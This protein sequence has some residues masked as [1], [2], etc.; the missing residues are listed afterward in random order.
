MEAMD[1][2][3]RPKMPILMSVVASCGAVAAG[4]ANIASGLDQYEIWDIVAG[5]G[6]CLLPSYF[7]YASSASSSWHKKRIRLVATAAVI[8]AAL[9]ILGD[10]AR[11]SG[12]NPV[13]WL[14]GGSRVAP[15]TL[16]QH[17][18]IYNHQQVETDGY[19][20]TND[21]GWCVLEAGA[22]SEPR[23]SVIALASKGLR[24]K[25]ASAQREWA[26]VSGIF[27][28]YK[29]SKGFDIPYVLTDAQGISAT[30]R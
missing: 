19:L 15:S 29:T 6:F 10:V 30:L 14:V 27:R 17:P 5:V 26:S 4:L 28:A 3:S 23:S 2:V 12:I 18:F 22:A 7:L 21:R 13:K 11:I 20:A 16:I 8:A 1:N 9:V 25:P 24:C